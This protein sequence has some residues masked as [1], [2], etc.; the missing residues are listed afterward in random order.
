MHH[1]G[2]YFYSIADEKCLKIWDLHSGALRNSL[3]KVHE[4]YI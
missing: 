4:H 2:R 1:S 3:E